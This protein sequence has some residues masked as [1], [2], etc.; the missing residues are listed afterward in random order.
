MP[1]SWAPSVANSCWS[2]STSRRPLH[3][4]QVHDVGVLC[5]EIQVVEILGGQGV[6]SQVGVGQVDAL[7]AAEVCATGRTSV[8]T[9]T[10][11]SSS[12]CS[13]VPPILPSSSHTRSPRP[14]DAN[15]CGR[16]Q[17]M[18]WSAP[19]RRCQ[20]P[21]PSTGSARLV[22]RGGH[23]ASVRSREFT[24]RPH[25]H[26]RRR[27]APG[28]DIGRLLIETQASAWFDLDDVPPAIESSGVHERESVADPT[29]AQPFRVLDRDHDGRG[30][31]FGHL[32]AARWRA[33]VAD[34]Q[35]IAGSTTRPDASRRGE[36][37]TSRGPGSSGPVRSFGPPRSI[38][39]LHVGPL[40]RGSSARRR[41]PATKRRRHRVHSSPSATSMP[42]ATRPSI[43]SSSTAASLGRVTMIR[44]ER[45]GGVG[46]SSR[47]ALCPRIALPFSRVTLRRCRRSV[48]PQQSGQR[49]QH[50][51]DR[52]KHGRFGSAQRRQP[53][54][55]QAGL[56]F[57]D[58]VFAE[59]DVVH[60]VRRGTP[61]Q[62]V[63]RLDVADR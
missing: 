22:H 17:P 21:A 38:A 60:E 9:M 57:T 29:A 6:E 46:P 36:I 56:Q 62:R 50:R 39:I 40:V 41:H 53:E 5:D 14:A 30:S 47:V 27:R 13:I 19:A 26:R 54:Q 11:E 37:F 24:D 2:R 33:P 3:E 20:V 43:S 7:A 4:R 10:I 34:S 52:G 51:L 31:G 44:V 42:R 48:E 59:F 8:T 45:R 55:T 61:V 32:A 15:T 35:T 23:G 49:G 25:H 58:V 63:R 28:A 18:W 16:L 12:T 1:T